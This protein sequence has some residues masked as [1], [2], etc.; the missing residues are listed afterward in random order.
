M[1]FGAFIL[2]RDL[3]PDFDD[4]GVID[5][6]DVKKVIG[7]ITG[8]KSDSDDG[9]DAE[10]GSDSADSDHEDGHGEN[11]IQIEK[12]NKKKENMEKKEA[13]KLTMKEI[14]NIV[15]HV[16]VDFICTRVQ[17]RLAFK[18]LLYFLQVML[19]A[20]LNKSGTITPQEFRYIMSKS[21]DFSQN[22]R[23]RV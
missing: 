14:D 10:G 8:R 11:E 13:G 17:W 20:D 4:N 21:P 22:F 18:K 7:R 5:K 16:S 3:T 23:L 12:E 19:E 1:I 6:T 9:E 2:S 15:K